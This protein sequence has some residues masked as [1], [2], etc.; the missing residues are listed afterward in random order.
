M[1]DIYCMECSKNFYTTSQGETG[2]YIGTYLSQF[3]IFSL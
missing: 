3:Q 1:N 2:Y